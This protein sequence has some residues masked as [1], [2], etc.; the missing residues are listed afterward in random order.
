MDHWMDRVS[1]DETAGSASRFF[2][3]ETNLAETEKQFE[4]TLDLAG[5][6]PEDFNVEFDDGQLWITGE[7]KHEEQQEGKTYHRV[8]RSYGRFRRGI[9]LGTEVDADKIEA[10]Y[11][12][13]ILTVTVPK[14][15]A[16]CP[17]KIEVKG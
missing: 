14:V 4:V 13:G 10:S 12:D 17:R 16:A 15:E 8:E 3:P 11:K 5:L 6:K 9:S 2:A 1:G 7:R